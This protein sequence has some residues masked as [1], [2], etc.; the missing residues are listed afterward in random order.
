MGQAWPDPTARTIRPL[1]P[2][3][4]PMRLSPSRVLARLPSYP[5]LP[6]FFP[7]PSFLLCVKSQVCLL[8]DV[9]HSELLHLQSH[10]PRRRLHPAS[11]EGRAE[12]HFGKEGDAILKPN[13]A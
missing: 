9:L 13:L 6:F 12:A 8:L 4:L 10:P 1:T 11:P 7:F 2:P 3:A 5:R